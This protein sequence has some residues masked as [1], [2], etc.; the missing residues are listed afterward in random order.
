[1]EDTLLYDNN[2][3]DEDI[4]NIVTGNPYVIS[5]TKVPGEFYPDLDYKNY[6]KININGIAYLPN[7]D[8]C[9]AYKVQYYGSLLMYALITD[10]YISL[11]YSVIGFWP[12]SL[13]C[14]SNIVGLYA[15]RNFNEKFMFIY[16]II[17]FISIIIRFSI[18]I[19]ICL[20]YNLLPISISLL[21][22]IYQLTIFIQLYYFKNFI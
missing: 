22:M 15:I 21:L 16:N 7:S 12:L 8:F 4:I 18:F 13:L 10:I 2:I 3:N 17:L 11:L 20:N 1:M 19:Y 9:K 5:A 14:F 6:T